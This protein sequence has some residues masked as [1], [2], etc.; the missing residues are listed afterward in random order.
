MIYRPTRNGQR[1]LFRRAGLA[2]VL[3][4]VAVLVLFLGGIFRSDLVPFFITLS[5]PFFHAASVSGD[6]LA[7]T[8]SAITQT[9]QELIE[10]NTNLKRELNDLDVV[11]LVNIQL[12]EENFQLKE[13]LGR[14][15]SRGDGV[16]ATILSRPP[17]SSYDTVLL[18]AGVSE[19][20]NEGDLVEWKDVALGTVVESY[21]RAAKVRLFSDSG[22]ETNV[23]LGSTTVAVTATGQGGQN[24]RIRVPRTISVTEG[25]LVVLPSMRTMVVGVVARVEEAETDSFQTVLFRSPL[26]IELLPW[27][28]VHASTKTVYP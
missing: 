11:G 21:P 17:Q 5:R 25:D 23:L 15:V 3:L 26:N 27:V 16:L 24:F 20:I 14:T 12:R 13:V 7:N 9:K 1:G 8:V 28:Y 10:E 19:G 4:G 22:R 18:D 6:G 2:G